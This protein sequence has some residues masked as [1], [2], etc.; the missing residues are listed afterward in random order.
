MTTHNFFSSRLL[1][2]FLFSSFL[3]LYLFKKVFCGSSSFVE[4]ILS[5]SRTNINLSFLGAYVTQDQFD[6]VVQDVT[7]INTELEEVEAETDT[8]QAEMDQVEATEEIQT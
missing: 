7:E 5:A 6:E 8:L 2:E 3:D 1:F 4:Y